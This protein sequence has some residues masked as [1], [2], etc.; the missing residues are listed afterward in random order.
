MVLT[1]VGCDAGG[2]RDLADRECC[3]I[4][5]CCDTDT[6]IPIGIPVEIPVNIS[7]DSGDAG[8]P[9]TEVM[10]YIIHVFLYHVFYIMLLLPNQ[11]TERMYTSLG[12]ISTILSLSPTRCPFI[13]NFT[14][15]P[16]PH[17][18]APPSIASM[19]FSTSSLKKM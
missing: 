8:I 1:P 10:M 16:S 5:G 3:D 2:D 7:I 13:S 6:G 15:S 9:I 19:S 11:S 4:A 12:N 14:R 17:V 18:S